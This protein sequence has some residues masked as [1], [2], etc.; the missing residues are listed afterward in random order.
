MGCRV[1][2]K[3]EKNYERRLIWAMLVYVVVVIVTTW[4][5]RHGHVSGWA[6]YVVAVIPC[7]PVL[8][9]I[10]VLALYLHEETDE[11]QRLLAVR[12]IL[13]GGA[14]MLVVSAFSD[15]LR[16]FANVGALSPFMMFSVFW[17]TFGIAQG[18]QARMNRAGGDEEP[19]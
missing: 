10:H 18:V 5:V 9:L 4:A 1:K 15:F 3:A 7:L 16:S 8:R 14:A 11:F 2:S 13:L 6:L 17:V 19:A 12:A